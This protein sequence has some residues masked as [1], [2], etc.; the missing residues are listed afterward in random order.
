MWGRE[1]YFGL[2]WHKK[3]KLFISMIICNK[4]NEIPR[5]AQNDD[6]LLRMTFFLDVLK[7]CHSEWNEAKW[8]AMKNLFAVKATFY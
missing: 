3:I 5:C 6:S 8:N 2:V 4:K 1:P 7:P